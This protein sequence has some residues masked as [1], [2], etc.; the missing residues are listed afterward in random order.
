MVQGMTPPVQCVEGHGDLLVSNGNNGDWPNEFGPTTVIF[1]RVGRI[2]DKA[3][4]TSEFGPTAVI[5]PLDLGKE[6]YFL[7]D[8]SATLRIMN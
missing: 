2:P 4:G 1:T 3:P 5:C 8:C 6:P 7:C